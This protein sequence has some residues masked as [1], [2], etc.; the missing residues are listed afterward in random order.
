LVT[1]TAPAGFELSGQQKPFGQT[2]TL[3]PSSGVINESIMVRIARSDTPGV[4]RGAVSATS[5]GAAS[6]QVAVEGSILPRPLLTMEGS[7]AA[8]AAPRNQPSPSQSVVVFGSDLSA[9]VSVTAPTGFQVSADNATFSNR[10]QFSPSGGSLTA[11][12]VWIRLAPN[13]TAGSYGGNVTLSSTGATTRA[14]PVAGILGADVLGRFVVDLDDGAD[15]LSLWAPGTLRL[16]RRAAPLAVEGG[17][18]RTRVRVTAKGA[19]E[20]STEVLLDVDT[21]ARDVLL[22]GGQETILR[23]TPWKFHCL[24]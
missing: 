14:L 21:G 20:R 15:R 18:A 17:R 11:R 8:F 2:I 16:P 5:P 13:S 10:V 12:N 7:L 22:I 9:P 24:K 19:P 6:V 4:V 3:S 1:L 23:Y